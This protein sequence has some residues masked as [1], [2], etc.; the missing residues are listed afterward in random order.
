MRWA[1]ALCNQGTSACIE[2]APPPASPTA[3]ELAQAIA[4]QAALIS[5]AGLEEEYNDVVEREEADEGV[6]IDI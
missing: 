1:V 4:Y 3:E 6:Y 5:E 2:A